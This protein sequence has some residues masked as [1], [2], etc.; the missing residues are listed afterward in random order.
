MSPADDAR[1]GAGGASTDADCASTGLERAATG[2][3]GGSR[4]GAAATPSAAAEGT[5]CAETDGGDTDGDA[6]ADALATTGAAGASGL[7]LAAASVATDR[8]TWRAVAQPTSESASTPSVA[9]RAERHRG[10]GPRRVT[11]CRASIPPSDVV[12][13][14][15]ATAGTATPGA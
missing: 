7:P 9:T 11:L 1:G 14:G 3:R 10:A 15:G 6:V 12:V 2:E 4:S 13:P 5:R 8:D